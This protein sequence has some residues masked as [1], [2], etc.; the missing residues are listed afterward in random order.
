MDFAI[1]YLYGLAHKHTHTRARVER[2]RERVTKR[3]RERD[4][5]SDIIPLPT[6]TRSTS[7]K[8]LVIQYTLKRNRYVETNEQ[9]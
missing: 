9:K 6:M 7:A 2:K 5:V 4:T 1:Y 8:R 3:E